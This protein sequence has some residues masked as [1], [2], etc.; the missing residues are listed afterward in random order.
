MPR[1]PAFDRVLVVVAPHGGYITSGRKRALIKSRHYRMSGQRL[2][3]VEK[4]RALGVLV[5]GPPR[6]VTLAGFRRAR[7]LHL[8]TEEERRRWWA[9]KTHFW[10]YPVVSRRR[11]RAPIPVDYPQGPQVFVRPENLT[12]RRI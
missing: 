4:K 6:P 12:V 10:L 8:V 11:L 7:P 5:L 9:R 3:V 1:L 2:L